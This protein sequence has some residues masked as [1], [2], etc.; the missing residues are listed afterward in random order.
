MNPP[1]LAG[2]L[3][4]PDVSGGSYKDDSVFDNQEFLPSINAGVSQLGLTSLLEI[5]PVCETGVCAKLCSIS[6]LALEGVSYSPD[7]SGVFPV[8]NNDIEIS[9]KYSPVFIGA[10]TL[11]LYD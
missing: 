1:V 10:S 6:T 2:V 9:E 11:E 4:S 8:C 3:F 7:V 5:P